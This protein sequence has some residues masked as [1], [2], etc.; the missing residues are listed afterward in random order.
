MDKRR[1]GFFAWLRQAP[2]TPARAKVKA[3][4]QQVAGDPRFHRV[5]RLS[6]EEVRMLQREVAAATFA[7][8][9]IVQG[10][11]A[12]RK[13]VAEGGGVLLGLSPLHQRRRA[14]H[15][16]FHLV[17][18]VRQKMPVGWEPDS[19]VAG[20]DRLEGR[21]HRLDAN[22]AVRSGA[23]DNRVRRPVRRSRLGGFRRPESLLLV[24]R[25]LT[26]IRLFLRLVEIQHV[27]DPSFSAQV[28][29][30]LARAGGHGELG[31][32]RFKCRGMCR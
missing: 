32:G 28:L 3:L 9:N 26:G 21:V 19:M 10:G 18:D 1:G 20:V 6:A 24:V 2:T 16:L 11:Y 25:I 27:P 29:S 8:S 5:A 15:E 17:R 23:W 31:S 13:S 30:P 4:F 12:G 7:R 22:L 14:A